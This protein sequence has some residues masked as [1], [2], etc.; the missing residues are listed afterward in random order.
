MTK[1]E[2]LIREWLAA[3]D[4]HDFDAFED[5]VHN[6][7]V[8]HAPMGIEIRGL[9]ELKEL[10]ANASAPPSEI[11]HDIQEVVTAGSTSQRV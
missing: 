2:S 3:A 11:R 4:A 10:W 8:A 6:D 5:Y 7:C 1:N 9:A